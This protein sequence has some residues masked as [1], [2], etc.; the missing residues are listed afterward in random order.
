M[1]PRITIVTLGV[2]DLEASIRFYRDG[3][4]LPLRDRYPDAAFFRLGGVTLGLYPRHL[5]AQDANVA[6]E[7]S[8]FEGIT[9]AHNVRSRG[10]VKQILDEA[11]AAGGKIVQPPRLADWGGYSGYVAD[12]DGHLWEVACTPDGSVE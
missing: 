10:E 11:A 9:L 2:R 6:A 4:G 12:P 3:L 1:E 8:G 7:G 5:L